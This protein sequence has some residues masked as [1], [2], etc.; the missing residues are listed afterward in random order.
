M[1][2]SEKK[3]ESRTINDAVDINVE[4]CSSW[5]PRFPVHHLRPEESASFVDAGICHLLWNHEGQCIQF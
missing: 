4:S 2:H 3:L 5:L 1:L